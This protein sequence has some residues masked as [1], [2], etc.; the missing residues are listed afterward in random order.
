MKQDENEALH[1]IMM[2]KTIYKYLQK[3]TLT[4]TWTFPPSSTSCI[5]VPT[6]LSDIQK[7][8]SE[9]ELPMNTFCSSDLI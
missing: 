6:S 2:M 9:N 8:D 7:N 3:K 1:L 4:L 5:S